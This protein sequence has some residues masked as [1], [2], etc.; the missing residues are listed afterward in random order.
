MTKAIFAIHGAFSTPVVFNY[1]QQVLCEYHWSLFDYSGVTNDIAGLVK[2]AESQLSGLGPVHVVG[3]SMGGLIALALAEAP[4]VQSVATIAT[5]LSGL[6][7]NPLQLFFSQS[8]F[9]SD[10][11]QNSRFVKTLQQGTYNKPVQHLI[12]TAGFNPWITE[13][14]DGVVTLRS[15]KSWRAG[16]QVELHSNHSEVMQNPATATSLRSFWTKS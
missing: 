10:I 4:N 1:L 8:G 9:L 5:P 13:A 3:H 11:A 7:L 6:D 2:K 16:S 12:T 15:Q 14:S